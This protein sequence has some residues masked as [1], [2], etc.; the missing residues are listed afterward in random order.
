[1]WSK[2]S[3]WA[4]I[5]VVPV[6]VQRLAT[7]EK[8]H[9]TETSGWHFEVVIIMLRRQ[10]ASPETCLDS[11]IVSSCHKNCNLS[12]GH[13][14]NYERNI[15]PRLLLPLALLSVSCNGN[16]HFYLTLI[17]SKSSAANE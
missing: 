11:W 1:M 8:S 7:A 9:M 5:E 6:W 4:R 17:Y 3:H 12:Q 13:N 2:P 16:S 10:I 14:V 15:T